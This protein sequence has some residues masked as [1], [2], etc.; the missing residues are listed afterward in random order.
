[1]DNPFDYSRFEATREHQLY[2]P[3]FYSQFERGDSFFVYGSR[4][5]GKTYLLKWLDW[6][7]RTGSGA[8]SQALPTFTMS[9]IIGLYVRVVDYE[10]PVFPGLVSPQS[11]TGSTERAAAEQLFTNYLALLQCSVFCGA[12]AGLVSRNA[13]PVNSAEETAFAE[14]V[15]EIYGGLRGDEAV[16][17]PTFRG[18][19][20]LFLAGLRRIHRA[21]AITTAAN[22]PV[23]AEAG[24]LDPYASMPDSLSTLFLEHC[25]NMHGWRFVMCVDEAE[26]L[27]TWQQRCLN[28]FIR[29]CKAPWSYV[30]AFVAGVY[31]ARSTSIHQQSLGPD[32][33]QQFRLDDMARADYSEMVDG[34]I[35]KRLSFNNLPTG[36][37]GDLVGKITVNDLLNARL[38]RSEKAKAR[39]L[40]ENARRHQPPADTA[41]GVAPPIYEAW[42]TLHDEKL[43]DY[44]ELPASEKRGVA[45]QRLR[46]KHLSAYNAI[47]RELG[48]NPVYAGFEALLGLSDSCIRDLLRIL[49][50]AWDEGVSRELGWEDME[51]AQLA[52]PERRPLMPIA[53]QDKAARRAARSKLSDLADDSLAPD[54]LTRLV[55]NLGHLQA[56]L[57]RRD[58][59]G[60]LADLGAFSIDR[61]LLTQMG[62]LQHA[63]DEGIFCGLLIME[64]DPTSTDRIRLRPHNLLA[65]M[66]NL[67]YR[68]PTAP[69]LL[70]ERLLSHLLRR[71]LAVPAWSR[72]LESPCSPDGQPSMF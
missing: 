27:Q 10:M 72:L 4:G 16:T 3:R 60:L 49:Y 57:I 45:S 62:E 8:F 48:V 15:R 63:I 22:L 13:I 1:M 12:L 20:D 7:E 67:P 53:L 25:P 28:A 64:T 9:R 61:T 50:H 51:R 54:A 68:K 26:A 34:V 23:L 19:K 44:W 69:R 30:V 18:T 31:D 46:K 38:K 14:R 47:C 5:T 65:P 39:R 66:N 36:K 40:L 70:D 42:L 32:D 37:L 55:R 52:T 41:R 35:A 24:L 59:E 33:I 6:S 11:P 29:R 17:L 21:A 56:A 2:T 58:T 43:A 71:D